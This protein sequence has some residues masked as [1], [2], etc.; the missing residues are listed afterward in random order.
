M[1][2]VF[3]AALLYMGSTPFSSYEAAATLALS[4]IANAAVYSFVV[5]GRSGLPFRH[6]VLLNRADLGGVLRWLASRG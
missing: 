1:N 6:F 4:Y 3:F 5:A 2:L